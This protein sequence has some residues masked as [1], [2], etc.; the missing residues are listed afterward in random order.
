MLCI[1]SYQ[2]A[3]TCRDKTISTLER[4]GLKQATVF[5]VKEEYD[6][7]RALMP[8]WV[9]VS[10]G[11]KGL[12]QQRKFMHTRVIIVVYHSMSISNN[13]VS[14]MPIYIYQDRSQLQVNDKLW[15]D[16]GIHLLAIYERHSL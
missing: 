6:E 7:Y 1:P 11:V 13:L 9:V 15:Q 4:H 3:K 5:V 12:V 2:R 14:N 8:E 16:G 10:I